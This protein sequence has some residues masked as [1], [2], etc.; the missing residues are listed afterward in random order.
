VIGV[1]WRDGKEWFFI[2]APNYRRASH[3]RIDLL[4]NHYHAFVFEA[5]SLEHAR[6]LV[7]DLKKA[8]EAPLPI[9]LRPRD[10]DGALN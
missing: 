9:K 10:D 2:K 8:K 4:T 3:A 6:T 5:D 1:A 7:F